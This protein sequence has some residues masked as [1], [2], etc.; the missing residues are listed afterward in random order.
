MGLPGRTPRLAAVGGRWLGFE[1]LERRDLLA[2][3]RLVD[4]NMLN[5]PNDA[6]SDANVQTVLEAIGNETVQ[7][8]TKR[9]DILAVQ[10]TD[11][12]GPGG[13]SIG[14][15]EAIFDTLYPLSDYASVV[16]T[17]DG[18]GDA[19][20][21]VYDTSTLSLVGSPVQIAGALTHS[22]LRG[23]FRP[24]GTTGDSD[25]YV[26]TIHLKSGDTG[27]DISKRADEATILRA[28]ADALGEGAHVL[29]VG[30][31][32]MKTSAEAAYSTFLSAGAA[33]LQDVYG[34]AGA[35]NWI[36][37][38]AFKIL[39]SQDPSSTMDD[40][41]DIQFATGE[42]F[43][44]VGLEYVAN[45]YHVFGNNGTHTLD[46]PITT[47]T[48][49][50]PTVL[51][52]LA[53]ASDHLP[54][55]ADYETVISTPNV[56]ITETGGGTKV[57]EGGL[58]DTYYVV[59][60]TAPSANVTVT[61]TPNTQLDVGSGAG[62]ASMLTFTPTNWQTP[63]AVIVR[64][65]NDLAGE[66]N[67]TGTIAHTSAS[68][69]LAYNG[70]TIAGV[71]AT[72]VDND[73]PLIVINELD[74]DQVMTDAGEFIELYDGGVGN[75]SL[76]GK[77]LV[78]FNGGAVNDV[79]YLTLDLTGK[80]TDAN[81]FFVAGNSAVIGSVTPTN[82]LFS[83]NTLQN[84]AD[85]VA[86]YAA[87]AS[88]FPNGTAPTAT[89]LI[90]A[91]VY[92][93]A[94]ADDAPLL[95]VLTPGQP[96][97]NE[98][99]NNQGTTQAIA[100]VPDGGDPR[101]TTT[102][103]VQTPT[104]KATNKP[105]TV[106]VLIVQSGTRVDVA[107]GGATDS[108]QIALLTIPTS[109]VTVTVD[110]DGQT[111]L[112]AGAGAPIMLTFT[113][114][115]ALVPQTVTVTAVDDAVVE[116]AHSSLITHAVA[117]ADTAYNGLSVSNVV[118]S[119]LDNDFV[120]PPV[121][122][123]TEIM[124]NPATTEGGAHLPEWI[125]VV[126]AGAS[127]VDLG[128]WTIDDEDATN[129]GAIPLG[130]VLQPGQIAVF[131]DKDFVTAATFRTAWTVPDSALVVGVT[132]GSLSN[133]PG[134]PGDE[135][136]QLLNSSAMQADVVN[137]DNE[138]SWPAISGTGG[139]SIYLKGLSLDNTDG[140]NWAKSVTG[141]A[142]AVSPTGPT[143]STS[144]I[145]SPGRFFLPGDY[146]VNGYV[147]AADYILWRK[148]NLAA[149][150]SGPTFGTPNGIVDQ[151]DYTFWLANFGSVG[152]YYTGGAGAGSGV[153][154]M[155]VAPSQ[156]VSSSVSASQP[157]A[158]AATADDTAVVEVPFIPMQTSSTA[159]AKPHVQ[160]ESL[161]SSSTWVDLLLVAGRPS[162]SPRKFAESDSSSTDASDAENLAVDEF[163]A[164]LDELEPT[165]VGSWAS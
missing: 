146:N 9:I 161:Q 28:D 1:L 103:V 148:G 43:N 63:Q 164:S 8:N 145:G 140:A 31:F 111:N 57:I 38:P 152:A 131:F 29:F 127:T 90:D 143:F 58:Y 102:Y 54:V 94:D 47:G 160:F 17:E 53:A 154:Q 55:V 62:V 101:V 10:E 116:G 61:V 88:A 19:T 108:Y 100:R 112:G 89:G 115:N 87:L 76:T 11:P 144:D 18:G 78:F 141:A 132:W 69:D 83:D 14:R 70:L 35:G 26:Y 106:G 50:S 71:T 12:A 40:R 60:D 2:V 80:T 27:T 6:T 139:P 128:G 119:V 32:N 66:G 23:L 64:A 113:P 162:E 3:F 110:P 123:I 86:L 130:T 147:D 126:N 22:I 82:I 105:Q 99:L 138:N 77:I 153:A 120:S 150:G 158:V 95:A 59:L 134:G 137:F 5:G 135:V 7:G 34:L 97:I 117:S 133:D 46:M 104:P 142:R 41:F 151:A 49:A 65:D 109:N 48:G 149:D 15:V 122:V 30:D 85:A 4:W 129:W 39:H 13:N 73:A 125:E 51:A 36:D 21:F 74:A 92:D 25:F 56:R 165:A 75:V 121:I 45:S 124:Y 24:T 81:G 68:A 52:A 118:A 93:T 156:A 163:F 72:I 107:E 16:S 79:S 155:E 33:Q 20:G 98:D 157:V 84:G 42:F 37:N 91:V 44:G 67:H 159:S 96:Q 136:I 114:A